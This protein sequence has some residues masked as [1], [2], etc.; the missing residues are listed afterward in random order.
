MPEGGRS[1]R[2][3]RCCCLGQAGAMAA[4]FSPDTT[5]RTQGYGEVKRLVGP[6]SGPM[7][8]SHGFP[9]G[10]ARPS[11]LRRRP[12]EVHARR[13]DLVRLYPRVDPSR[14]VCR[15]PQSRMASRIGCSDRPYSVRL[16]STFGGTSG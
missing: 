11:W 5:F 15:V 8:L 10:N 2:M 1:I 7:I 13:S 6:A 14:S 4:H 12:G 16:Y 9:G 3:E